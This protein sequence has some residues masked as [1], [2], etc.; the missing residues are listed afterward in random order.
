VVR[1]TDLLATGT[2]RIAWGL[3]CSQTERHEAM[4]IASDKQ[5]STTQRS[6]AGG[7]ASAEWVP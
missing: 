1:L 5:E 2:L 6:G 4:A 3:S 7:G